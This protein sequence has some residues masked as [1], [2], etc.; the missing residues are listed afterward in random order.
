MDFAFSEE[1]EA[2]RETL[3]RFLAEKSPIAEVRRW[4]ET[5]EGYNPALW[6]QMAAELGLQGLHLPEHVG[7]QGFGFLELGIVFE[8]M[9]RVLL[10]AP[11]FSTVGLAAGAILNAGSDEQQRALLPAIASGECIATLALVE[12]GGDTAPDSIALEARRDGDGF[13]LSGT[14]RPVTDGHCADLLVVAARLEGTRGDDG[15]TLLTLNADTEGVT[16]TPLESLDLTRRQAR[17]EFDGARAEA[18][19]EPGGAGPALR[20]TLD[21]AAVLLAAESVGGADRC[22][23]DAVAYALQR[24]QFARPI[25]GFQAIKHK[26]A[27]VLLEVESARAAARWAA[28]VAEADPPGLAAAA[29]IAK[30]VCGDAYLRAASESIQIHGGIGFTWEADPHLYLKRAKTNE[31]LLGDPVHH[32]ARLMR[33][34]AI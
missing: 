19:G 15:I 10:C 7:G 5:P 21:Q 29:S 4:M 20:R 13:R 17:L 27:E 23:A 8:E 30:A 6:K 26:C 3:R 2:F 9:G 28:W 33:E 12:D 1:Q 32:R 25:G 11:Y 34:L 14:K 22:L 16:R 31:I 18:L 24:V